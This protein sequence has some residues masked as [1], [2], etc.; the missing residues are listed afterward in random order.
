MTARD[1]HGNSSP[2]AQERI[3]SEECV[4][5]SAH[6]IADAQS[7][8]EFTEKSIRDVYGISSEI[9]DGRDGR[10]VHVCEDIADR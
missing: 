10:Y 5:G 7:G 9:V 3:I 4:S 1:T 2:N 6:I 8:R